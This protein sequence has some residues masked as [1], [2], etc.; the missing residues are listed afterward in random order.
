MTPPPARAS[1]TRLGGRGRQRLITR[2]ATL[3]SLRVTSKVL[4]K[5]PAPRFQ[6][7]TAIA[8]GLFVVGLTQTDPSLDHTGA[9]RRV[10]RRGSYVGVVRSV[11][12]SGALERRR[13][14]IGG[15]FGD[16]STASSRVS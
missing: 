10:H 13:S 2:S 15:R 7:R 16:C 9:R 4:A 11:G 12:G 14:R 5:G 8:V 6:G 1:P 3:I